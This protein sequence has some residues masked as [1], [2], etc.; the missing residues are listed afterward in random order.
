NALEIAFPP[1][2][3]EISRLDPELQELYKYWR[4]AFGG[5]A[6][7]P[8]AIIA[9]QGDEVVFSCDALGLRPLWFGETEIEFFASSEKG[10]VPLEDMSNDPRPLAPG[11]KMGLL[12]RRDIGVDV[13]EHQEMQQRIYELSSHRYDFH[14]LNE[15]TMTSSFFALGTAE[16]VEEEA[17]KLE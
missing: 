15:V 9:R 3:S 6:Q 7:G 14:K 13:Y 11:E 1:V 17:P 5:L 4:R 12:L 2:W 16:E 8:A 10:V